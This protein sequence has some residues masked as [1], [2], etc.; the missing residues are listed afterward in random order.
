MESKQR[1]FKG[2]HSPPKQPLG[3]WGSFAVYAFE[4]RISKRQFGRYAK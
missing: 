4:T 3:E 2:E 1:N